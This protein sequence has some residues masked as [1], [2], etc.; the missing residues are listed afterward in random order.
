M[1]VSL[2]NIVT[3]LHTEQTPV[4]YSYQFGITR[5]EQVILITSD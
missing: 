4:H 2:Y 3:F 1:L 5:T